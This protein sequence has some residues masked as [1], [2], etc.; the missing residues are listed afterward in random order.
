[1]HEILIVD[2]MKHRKSCRH[3]YGVRVVSKPMDQCAGTIGD[4][5][6]DSGTRDNRA[7]RSVAT[8]NSL[9][10]DHYV[11]R[12]APM[13][14]GE[15]CACASETGHDLIGD[16][17]SSALGASLGYLGKIGV[18]RS[19]GSE[20]CTTDGLKD[21]GGS[22]VVHRVEDGVDFL[23]ILSSAVGASILAAIA[24][25]RVYL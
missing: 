6:H 9:P 1:M 13:L 16:E 25:R 18:R 12:N 19:N 7:K 14:D 11:R 4:C 17:E 22:F 15:V 20:S 5:I 2:L 8:S 23:R 10:H 21:H 3:G 24:I